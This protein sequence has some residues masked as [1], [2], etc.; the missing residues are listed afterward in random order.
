MTETKKHYWFKAKRIVQDVHMNAHNEIG[1]TIEFMDGSV[2][3]IPG[4]YHALMEDGSIEVSS[5]YKD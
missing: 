2:H 3:F 5:R 1:R 4:A